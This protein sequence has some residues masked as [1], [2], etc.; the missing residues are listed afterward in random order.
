MNPDEIGGAER[1]E[2]FRELFDAYC[3]NASP[4]RV[5][6]VGCGQG[7]WVRL[8]NSRGWTAHGIDT[9][10]NFKPDNV[11]FFRAGLEDYSPDAPY[12]FITL[13]HC[14]EHLTDP[15]ASLDRLKKF[16]ATDGRL[17]IIVPNFGGAWSRLL[18]P[19]WHMLRT[20]HHVF[21]YTPS[22]LRALLRN[23]RYR[24][25]ATTTYSGYAPSIIK[26]RLDNIAIY[27]RGLNSLPPLRAVI[28][29]ANALLRP[30]LNKRLDTML[31]GAEIQLLARTPLQ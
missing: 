20:D 15:I 24:I 31:D 25:L 22:S 11:H 28:N 7:E 17:L 12:D 5:L 19:N 30:W 10:R 14:F 18:G 21:H 2:Y 16:L 4:G 27:R 23:C 13:V 9:F 26:L 1:P 6:D 8:L 3:K 29:R